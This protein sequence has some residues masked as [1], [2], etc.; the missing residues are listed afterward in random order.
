MWLRKFGIEHEFIEIDNPAKYDPTL[1][2]R[3]HRPHRHHHGRSVGHRPEIIVKAFMQEPE[4]TENCFVVGDVAAL[5]RAA[6][7]AEICY[8]N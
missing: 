3:A 8:Q 7:F 4:L 2:Y 5:R 1:A 6:G